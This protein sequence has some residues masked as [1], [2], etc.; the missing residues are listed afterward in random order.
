MIFFP[1]REK[2][3]T[4]ATK[5]SKYKLVDNGTGAQKRW[6]VKVL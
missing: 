2:A 3:R 6:A 1:T 5:N 4:F